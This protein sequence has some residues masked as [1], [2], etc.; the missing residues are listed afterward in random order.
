MCFIDD[1]RR[2]EQ[3]LGPESIW[4]WVRSK[5]LGTTGF[6]HS[7]TNMGFLGTFCKSHKSLESAAA[8][9]PQDWN[10]DGF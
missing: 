9:H 3:V 7:F 6:V 4:V 8:R 5:A 2:R 1:W 10:L